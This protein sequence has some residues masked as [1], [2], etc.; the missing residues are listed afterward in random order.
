MICPYCRGKGHVVDP[1]EFATLVRAARARE[2]LSLRK[3]ADR[4][5]LG[6]S[7]LWQIEQAKVTPKHA[8][9]AR[10]LTSYGISV[11]EP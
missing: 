8:T 11:S 5:G 6:T 2:G 10:L 1:E 7:T 4:A 9:R 3:A